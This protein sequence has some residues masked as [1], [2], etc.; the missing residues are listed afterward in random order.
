[1]VPYKTA[2]QSPL[3]GS[4]SPSG[5]VERR[6]ATLA[7]VHADDANRRPD[8]ETLG[9]GASPQVLPELGRETALGWLGGAGER[10]AR[11]RLLVPSEGRV[12]GSDRRGVNATPGTDTGTCRGPG[13][14]PGQT[15]S[16]PP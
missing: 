15:V 4:L 8:L 6:F 11:F 5:C 9:T 10:R 12:R 16:R 3:T 7:S 2:S 1:M 13:D 14:H